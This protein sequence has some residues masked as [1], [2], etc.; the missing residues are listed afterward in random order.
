[1]IRHWR[2]GVLTRLVVLVAVLA[3]V[4][5]ACSSDDDSSGISQDDLDAVSSELSDA[6]DQISALEGQLASAQVTTQVVQA[7]TLY[8]TPAATAGADDGWTNA[9]SD[10]GGLYLVAQ[11]DSSGP[12]AWDIAAHPRVYFTSESFQSNYFGAGG[13]DATDSAG[14]DLGNFAGWHVIDAYTKEVVASA[15]YQDLVPGEVNRGPHG[16]AVSPDG[17]WGYV[18]FATNPADDCDETVQAC[19]RVGYVMIVNTQTMKVDKILRQESYFEGGFRSQAVHHIQCWTQDSTGEDFCIIQWGFGANGGPHHIVKP[20]DNNRVF[21]SITYDD[22]KPM[23]HPFTTPDP[24]GQYVY[25]S[26]GS[27]WIREGHDTAGVA[28]FDID[29]GTHEVISHVGAH[30]IGIVHTQ[31]G[32]YTYVVDGHS[33]FLYKIDNEEGEVVNSA[34][35]GIAGPYGICLT[36]DEQ[37]AWINGKGEGTANLGNSMSI[38]DVADRFRAS[39]AHGNTP[40]YLGGSAS[41]VDHCAMHPDPDVPEVWI[42]NMKGWETIVVNYETLEVTDY[43][44]TP[45]NGDTHGMAFVWYDAGW[46]SGELM[47]DMGGPKSQTLQDY[48]LGEAAAAAAG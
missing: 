46:D 18:G 24:T 19:D 20:G 31:D 11:L 43:I 16:V 48:I 45:N 22:I 3:M 44:N 33:S 1:M 25:V 12:D 35:S 6:N 37:F 23:G 17:K 38:F 8:E 15:L 5:T 36:L 34:A 40:F 39:R 21:R 30:P 2:P 13:F 42:S 32:K 4:A 7:G 27:N 47:V 29:T 41:S 9:E 14:S 10:R 28:K 26:M